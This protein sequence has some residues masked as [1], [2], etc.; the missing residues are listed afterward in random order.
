MANVCPNLGCSSTS[1]EP[2]FCY[3]CGS[4]MIPMPSCKWCRKELWPHELFCHRCGRGRH[5][6]INGKPE[7]EKEKEKKKNWIQRIISKIIH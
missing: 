4:L 1:G 5:E 6:A 3:R 7:K 2:G